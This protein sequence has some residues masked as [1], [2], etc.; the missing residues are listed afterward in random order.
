MFGIIALGKAPFW[1]DFSK[2]VPQNIDV[3]VDNMHWASSEVYHLVNFLKNPSIIPLGVC[4][5][6]VSAQI[7]DLFLVSP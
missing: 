1:T 6:L 7:S 4:V 2:F 3:Q 5:F